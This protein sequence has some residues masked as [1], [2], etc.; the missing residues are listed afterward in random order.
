MWRRRESKPVDCVAKRRV[1]SRFVAK[2]VGPEV[3]KPDVSQRSKPN[4]TAVDN[5][6]AAGMAVLEVHRRRR[7]RDAS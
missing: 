3:T 4:P 2:W 5:A 6:F 7:A 1:S